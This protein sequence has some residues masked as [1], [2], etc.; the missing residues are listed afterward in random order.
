MYVCMYVL[1]CLKNVHRESRAAASCNAY[2][3]VILIYYMFLRFDYYPPLRG[4]V[5]REIARFSFLSICRVSRE[6]DKDRIEMEIVTSL[7]LSLLESP[8]YIHYIS[9]LFMSEL[10]FRNYIH[11]LYCNK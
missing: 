5:S 10:Y 11:I 7:S 9:D 2:T 4:A 6:I 8:V 3:F 1:E